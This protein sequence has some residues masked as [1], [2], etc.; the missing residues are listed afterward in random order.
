MADSWW[1]GS[2]KRYCP[3]DLPLRRSH[4]QY[5]RKGCCPADLPL[6]SIPPRLTARCPPLTAAGGQGPQDNTS[7]GPA[8][9]I[10]SS[11]AALRLWA[12]PAYGRGWPGSA[13]QH[14][15]RP[16]NFNP[17]LLRYAEGNDNRPWQLA[18][19]ALSVVSS[20]PRWRPV[21]V[22]GPFNSGIFLSFLSML[23]GAILERVH[24][25]RHPRMP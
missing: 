12:P 9:S 19:V 24:R 6:R 18:L 20:H 11:S 10:H 5:G 22:D 3:S 14:R 13:G 21:F 25:R 15:L 7:Y 1:V 17:F 23:F 2:R 16:C 8:T 4:R